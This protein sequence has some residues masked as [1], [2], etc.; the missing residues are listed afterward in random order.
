MKSN[1]N[2][3]IEVTGHCHIED[4]L[5]NVLLDKD[6]SV[7][8]QNISRVVARALSGEDNFRIH[9]IA[10]GN[11]GTVT[12]AAYTVSFNTP[13][14]G[15]PPDVR[16]WDSR[17]YNEVYSEIIDESNPLLGEDTGSAGPNVGNRP[18]GGSNPASDPASIPHV[19]G[20][21]VRS[22]EQGLTSQIIVT[23]V[24][25]P[26]EPSGQTINDTEVTDTESSFT[27]D[28]IGLYTTGAPAIDS[29]G[30]QDIDVGDRTASDN[31]GLIAGTPYEFKV[32][33][34]GGTETTISFT[35]PASGG[36]G[37]SGEILYGDLCEAIN[38]GDV[39]WNPAWGGSSPLPG[40]G[41]TISI[42][43]NTLAFSS[44]PGAQTYGF[45]RVISG[46]TGAVSTVSLDNGDS[47]DM[48]A[49]LN[50]PVGGAILTAVDGEDAGVQNNPTNSGTERERLLAHLIFSPILKSANR[51]LTITYILTVSVARTVS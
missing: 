8:P 49:A 25:N 28:E 22:N 33:I 7:H 27:F 12:D 29:N 46:S 23:A 32:T 17:I 10:F 38:I 18:G 2:F 20:P 50:L 9:R 35:T 1:L 51:L 43:N 39:A 13:N 30:S 5:G 42:T 37:T 21:G 26:G 6:N 31:T 4:D 45:L 19:S 44:I 14:D 24:L 47:N 3:D 15:Q 11:G 36:S 16:T 34:D 48:I 40:L 41:T